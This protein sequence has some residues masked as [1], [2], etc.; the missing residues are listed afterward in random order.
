VF[1]NI[2]VVVFKSV[3][4]LEIHQNN[5]CLFLKIIFDINTSKKSK[6]TNKN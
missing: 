4:R 1:E 5:I 3:L 6:D 2:K